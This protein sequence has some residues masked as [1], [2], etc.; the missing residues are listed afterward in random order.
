MDTTNPPVWL[1]RQE[2]SDREKVPSQPSPSGRRRVRGRST[3]VL[4]GI[5]ATASPM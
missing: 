4:V 5:A 2:L 3:P 1:T